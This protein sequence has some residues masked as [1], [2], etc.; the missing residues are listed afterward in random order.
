MEFWR[1]FW[2]IASLFFNYV[3]TFLYLCILDPFCE[4][5][6]GKKGFA[7]ENNKMLIIKTCFIITITII[8]IIVII[9]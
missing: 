2:F 6:G 8:I 4:D 1:R 9:I 3:L 7:F 5:D